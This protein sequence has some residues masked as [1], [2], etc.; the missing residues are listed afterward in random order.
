MVPVPPVKINKLNFRANVPIIQNKAYF[1]VKIQAN[2]NWGVGLSTRKVDLNK[3]PFG[4]DT[5]SWVLRSDSGIYHNN[6]QKFKTNH[7]ID[8]GDIIVS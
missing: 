6:A 3:L 8:E 7:S 5:E 4:N 1:E 2:G